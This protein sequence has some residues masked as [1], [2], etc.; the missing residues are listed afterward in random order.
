[1]PTSVLSDFQQRGLV[2]DVTSP[3]ELDAHLAQASRTV[4]VGFDPTADSLHVGNLVPLLG[5]RRFQLAGHPPIV[6]VAGGPR[7]IGEPAG[8]AGERAPHPREP[9][10]A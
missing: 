2:A 9:R 7:L 10:A 4:Y 3:G 6:P 1:M 8:Q 5:L